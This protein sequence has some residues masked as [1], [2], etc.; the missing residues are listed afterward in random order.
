MQHLLAPARVSLHPSLGARFVRGGGGSATFHALLIALLAVAGGGTVAMPAVQPSP[1]VVA[2]PSLGATFDTPPRREPESPFREQPDEPVPEHLP[3][4]VRN[5]VSGEEF[6][7]DLARIRQHRNDL[8]PFVTWDLRV[9][10]DRPAASGAGIAWPSAFAPASGTTSAPLTLSPGAMQALI[11]RAWS[12]RD[13]W[14]NLSELVT[15]ARQYDPDAG[16][17]ATA[18]N[19]YVTQNVPQPYEDWALPDPVFWITVTLAADDASILQF[20]I[21]YL[22]EHPA[23]RV[24]TELLFLLDQSAETSCDVLGD[25]LKAGTTDLPLEGTR[26]G[27]LDAYDLATSLAAAYRQWLVK[28][29]VNAAER[30]A[31]ART[32]ILRRIIDTSPDGYGA[33]DARFRLGELLWTTGRRDEAVAWWRGMTTDERTVYARAAR[34][35]RGAID[36]GAV[37]GNPARINGLLLAEARR[38]RERAGS[39]LDYFGSAAN[40]F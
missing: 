2:L 34:E 35:L 17:L 14:T 1:R 7:I 9:L 32:M 10:N 12:R 38:W 36:D 23:S 18:F 4:T 39:R 13:R 40:R 3:L 29:R 6:T 24:S 21:D 20:T 37:T 8:F 5:F 16:D 27:N 11:D 15:L 33:A 26:R 31:T 22:K 30:C 28:Y 25:V 19:G